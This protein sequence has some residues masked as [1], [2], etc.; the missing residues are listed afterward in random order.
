MSSPKGFRADVEAAINRH[1][2]ENGSATPDFILAEYL[3][4]CLAAWDRAIVARENWYGREVAT[5]ADLEYDRMIPCDVC[6]EP[7]PASA[8][9]TSA[10]HGHCMLAAEPSP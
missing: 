8:A 9:T 7:M 6:G 4:S 2:M 5:M 10:R 1:S 3:S